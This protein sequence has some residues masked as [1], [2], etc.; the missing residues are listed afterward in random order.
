MNIALDVSS[1]DS[2]HLSGVG[3]YIQNL[4]QRLHQETEITCCPVARWSRWNRRKKM[5]SHLECWPRLLLGGR[6]LFEFKPFDIWHGPDFRLPSHTVLKKIVT[7]HDLAFYEPGLTS[8]EFAKKRMTLLENMLIE[9]KPDAVITVSESTRQALIKRFPQYEHKSF[10]THLGVDLNPSENSEVP[11]PNP[12]LREKSHTRPYFLF[13]G[14]LEARKNIIGL[15]EAFDHFCSTTSKDFDLILIG[16]PG[17]DWE[18]IRTKLTQLKFRNN[19]LVKGYVSNFELRQYYQEAQALLYPSLLE[20]FGIPIVEAMAQGCPVLTSYGSST[21]EVA[22]SAALLV[23]PHSQEDLQ[24][25]IARLL[26][27][28]IQQ[29]L[30]SKGLQRAKNF[31]WQNTAQKTKAVYEWVLS[32]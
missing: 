24:K 28:N 6:T 25:G 23:D 26:D 12:P 1:L 9:K 27:K 16:K 18:N 21:E 19:V 3:I 5:A 20:G 30:S 8:P 15:I 2:A 22:G 7:V 10:V 29:K 14:N 11:L 31:S 13:V 4:F 32:Q 17:F